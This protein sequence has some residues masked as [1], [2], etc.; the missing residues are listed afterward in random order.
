MVTNEFEE[1][2]NR[3]GVKKEILCDTVFTRQFKEEELTPEQESLIGDDAY[4]EKKLEEEIAKKIKKC[5]VI[6]IN[7]DRFDRILKKIGRK[8][9]DDNETYSDIQGKNER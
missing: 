4:H 2:C 5:K 6:P 8:K 7:S 1:M 3:A 9:L